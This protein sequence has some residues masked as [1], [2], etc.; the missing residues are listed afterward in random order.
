MLREDLR[1]GLERDL[2]AGAVR[3]ADRRERRLRHAAAVLLVPD[4]AFAPDLELEPLGD[5][6]DRA[7]ADAVETGGNLVAR[8][9]ELSAGVEDGHDDFGRAARPLACMPT[10]MPRP[11]SSTVTEPSKW[12]ITSICVQ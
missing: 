11:S 2:G 1:I 12:T 5:G 8:V 7:D 6:V 4:V 10:G 3:I 9:V